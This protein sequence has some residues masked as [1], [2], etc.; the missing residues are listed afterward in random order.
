VSCTPPTCNIGFTPTLP[1]YA[2]AA[3]AIQVTPTTTTGG[4]TTTAFATTSGCGANFGCRTFLYSIAVPTNALGQG[5]QLPSTPNSF[6]FSRD[7]TKAY[8]GSD[9]GLMFMDPTKTPP[10][11]SSFNNAAGKVLAVSP[12]G[13][14]VVLSDTSITPNQVY[15]FNDASTTTPPVDLLISGA[16]AAAFSPDG[17]KAYILAGSTL[18]VYSP[19]SALKT[20]SLASSAVDVAFLPV[21][22]F[23][24]LA[25]GEPSA[26]TVRTTCTDDLAVDGN[27]TPQILPTKGTPVAIRAL[28]NG[29]TLLALDPPGLDV[30]TANTTPVGCPPTV[31]DP[32]PLPFVDLGQGNFSPLEF[33]TSSDGTRAYVIASDLQAVVQY[34]VF[35]GISTAIPLTGNATTVGGDITLDG[36]SL[37]VGGNDAKVHVVSTVS[38][39]DVQQVGLPA[40]LF[41]C[42]DVPLPCNPDLVRVQ[43]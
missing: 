19:Q 43:P 30:V 5:V 12:D 3:I 24:Y 29:T 25:G 39:G 15:I 27:N 38:G 21:G 10:T 28:L 18:Y 26:V 17:L 35:G 34:D 42:D 32:V 33:L 22:A 16:T 14:L 2:N 1:I 11:V 9:N 6:V 13:N 36:T 41:F 4:Q 8:L 40:N 7:G 20:V 31:S 37:Y 23:A